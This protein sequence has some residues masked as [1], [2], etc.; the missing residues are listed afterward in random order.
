MTDTRT[1]TVV[2]VFTN[3]TF[4]GTP[5]GIVHDASDFSTA[6][7]RAI[8]TELGTRVVGGID[9]DRLRSVGPDGDCVS[10]RT[11]IGALA[12]EPIADGPIETPDGSLTV[13]QDDRTWIEGFDASVDRVEAEY[14]RVAGALGIETAALAGV[15]RDLP[16]TRASIGRPTLAVPVNYFEQAGGLAPDPTAV[17]ALCEEASAD[18][19]AVYTFDTLD[20]DSTVHCRSFDPRAGEF[21][22]E[23][24]SGL[25][26]G[27]VGVGLRRFGEIDAATVRCEQGDYL[28]RPGRVVVKTD[29]VAVGGRAVTAVTGEIG[30]PR[31]ESDDLIEL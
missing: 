6:Q 15:G 22:E 3:D 16:I 9:G 23:H 11:A 5:T 28:D 10:A 31:D 24:A 25:V 8:G 17:R 18:A 4:A 19:L 2:D 21:R 7:L 1:I 29:D 12:V 14:D 30:V 26:A 20:P 13:S 27:A